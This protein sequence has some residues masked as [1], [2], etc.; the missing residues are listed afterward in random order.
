M[1]KLKICGWAGWIALMYT[2]IQFTFVSYFFNNN[3]NL[4]VTHAYSLDIYFGV[5][6]LLALIFSFGFTETGKILDKKAAL[7]TGYAIFIIAIILAII[8]VC[9]LFFLS[10]SFFFLM[11]S[12]I[13]MVLLSCSLIVFGINLMKSDKEELKIKMLAGSYSAI[14]GLLLIVMIIW[15]IFSPGVGAILLY[16]LIFLA[17]GFVGVNSFFFTRSGRSIQQNTEKKYPK[18]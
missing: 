9:S 3:Q 17:L 10:I 7:I 14:F 18:E 15:N 2:L 16:Y 1:N 12:L 8:Q 11:M 4:F 13:F 6:I 5:M